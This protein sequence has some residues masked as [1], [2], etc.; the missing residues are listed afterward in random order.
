[1][2][3]VEAEAVS[4]A[5]QDRGEELIDSGLFR[6]VMSAYPTGVAVISALSRDGEPLG[7]TVGSF[8][9]VS[10]NPPLVSFMADVNSSSWAALRGSDGRFCVNVLSAEQEEE[11]LTIARRKSDKF[12]GLD[13]EP[14][15]TGLPV[16]AGCLATIECV[17]E[18]VHTAGDHDIVIGRVQA[19]S[20]SPG[21]LP[22]LFFRGG[23]GSFQPRSV[24]A[25]EKTLVAHLAAVD[26]IRP[27]LDSL[28]AT[29]GGRVSLTAVQGSEL[30]VLA[31]AGW[32]DGAPGGWTGQRLPFMA[33]VGSVHAAWGDDEQRQRWLASATATDE[34]P[35]GDELAAWLEAV[36]ARGH[37]LALG[38]R[39]MTEFPDVAARVSSGDDLGAARR[40]AEV[41]G[42]SFEEC[43]PVQVPS[44][45]EHEFRS[46]TV[47]VT[48]EAGILGLAVW[49]APGLTPAA[50]IAAALEVLKK[51]SAQ[52]QAL[53]DALG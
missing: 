49:G 30:I 28:A 43:Y 17:T 41:A 23:Y 6:R 38:H 27:V 20:D 11:C 29:T 3:S 7:M 44:T 2:R 10:L 39:A 52:A 47:P 1:M 34:L 50:D 40:L 22:L 8:A 53:L 12:D 48:H 42:A 36:K 14:G 19:L 24:V 45:G 16:L 18:V 31:T 33:P 5:V 21:T 15:P 4:S 37:A 13:W 9:S 26:V 25:S 46:A 51:A 35:S 32:S